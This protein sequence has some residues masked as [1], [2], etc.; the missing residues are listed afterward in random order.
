[1]KNYKIWKKTPSI[2]DT[3]DTCNLEKIRIADESHDIIHTNFVL[4]I[5]HVYISGGVSL[6]ITVS[7]YSKK[8]VKTL[9]HTINE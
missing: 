6:K 2:I 9:L 5:M 4:W 7:G 3:I 8:S 1:M